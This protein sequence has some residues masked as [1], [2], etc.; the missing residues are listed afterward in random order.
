MGKAILLALIVSFTVSANSRETRANRKESFLKNVSCRFSGATH[1]KSL[2]TM[3]SFDFVDPENTV[4]DPLSNNSSP[5]PESGLLGKLILKTPEMGDRVNS[6]M[7]YYNKGHKLEKNLYFADV[8]VPTR[9]FTEGF[10]TQNGE[11]LIDEKGEKLIENFAIEYTSILKLGPNDQEGHYEIGLLSDDGARVFVKENNVWN[12]LVN[13]DGNHNTRLGCPFRTV[14]LKKDTELPIKILY[15]QGPRYHIANVLVWKL[16]RQSR[17]W[18]RPSG[19]SLCGIASNNLFFRKSY[20]R[21]QS[22]SKTILEKVGWKIVPALS[23]K[24][25]EQK[26]NPCTVQQLIISDFVVVSRQPTTAT[27]SWKTSVPSTS[28]LRFVSLYTGEEF[29]TQVDS[30]LVTDHVAQVN[31]LVQGEYYQ[32]EAISVDAQGK[33]VKSQLINLPP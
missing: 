32:V 25:P 21:N 28:Q 6:V 13:N 5:S 18:K 14:N 31:G 17:V 23:F 11:V 22:N 8:N 30:N 33:Q 24:M 2:P 26:Q 4:C 27:L 3:G 10:S 20:G 19:H 12:E 29:L 1:T 9:P 16:H 7:D 15:Y